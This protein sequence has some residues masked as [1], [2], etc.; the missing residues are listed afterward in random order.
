MRV[1]GL[2]TS[3][4]E[5]GVA[6]Y[7]AGVGIRAVTDNVPGT[8]NLLH[9]KALAILEHRVQRFEVGVDVRKQ[10]DTHG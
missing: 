7:E 10:R 9:S 8:N 5:T 6:L 3:C 1:L 2:E 4:D